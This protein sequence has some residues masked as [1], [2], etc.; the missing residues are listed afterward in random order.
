MAAG[1]YIPPFA[2]TSLVARSVDHERTTDDSMTRK[3]PATASNV[4]RWLTPVPMGSTSRDLPATTV[5]ARIDSTEAL[6][7]V[8]PED[9]A[10]QGVATVGQMLHGDSAQ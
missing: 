7:A 1:T 4:S 3:D 2:R 5:E 6:M 9:I 10:I 8:S